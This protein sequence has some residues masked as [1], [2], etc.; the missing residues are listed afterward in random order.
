MGDGSFQK[1]DSRAF[2]SRDG[3][4][5]FPCTES[6]CPNSACARTNGTDSVC[7]PRNLP[8]SLI[9]YPRNIVLLALFA[10]SAI[11]MEAGELTVG[12]RVRVSTNLSD[13]NLSVFPGKASY[14]ADDESPV[15]SGTFGDG[16]VTDYRFFSSPNDTISSYA[17]GGAGRVAMASCPPA[18][19]NGGGESWADV[20]T[21]N[22]P[23]VGFNT[24]PNVPT[25]VLPPRS[26]LSALAHKNS[27]GRHN[28]RS[29]ASKINLTRIYRAT[30]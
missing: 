30:I 6:T 26:P 17:D 12:S 19:I 2:D 18:N 29:K 24:S 5:G 27:S 11:G 7:V 1:P 16:T 15:V 4:R 10:I 21:T 28:M 25:T 9:R 20:W 8:R 23:G 22:D 14:E 3:G 13:F